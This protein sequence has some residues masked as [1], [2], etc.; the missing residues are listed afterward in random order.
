LTVAGINFYV[1]QQAAASAVTKK[2][3]F[4]GD[5]KT[6][7]GVFRPSAVAPTPNWLALSSLNEQAINFSWGGGYAPFFDVP[8]PGDYDGDGKTDYAIW[9]GA[10]T[11]W[12]IRR[13]SDGQ[14]VLVFYGA[15]YAPFNDIPTPGDFDGDGKTDIAVWR[16]TDGKWYVRSSLTGVDQIVPQ[17]QQGDVPLAA[18]FDGDGKCDFGIFRPSAITDNWR[19]LQSTTNTVVT[20]QWGGGYAPLF[21]TPVPADYDGDG[22]ADLAIWRGA[23]SIWY[24]RKSSDGGSILDLW[25]A[26]YDPYFD[27][28]TPGDYDGDGKA[29]IAVF[30]RSGTWFVK[31]SS[32]GS[33]FYR[34]H[35]QQDDIPCPS[36]GIR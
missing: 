16:P 13:S 18:D 2:A 1:T 32:N 33:P 14:P 27:I 15:N 5:G 34:D 24:I 7:L 25:G 36:V 28:P 10:D 11:F 17:G 31:H 12:Y 22:K 30:R 26:N 35:G 21:D 8:V 19:I 3:D 29:D 9:R 4:D 20:Y 6:D 23:D